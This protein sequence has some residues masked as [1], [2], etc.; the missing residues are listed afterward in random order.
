MK[1]LFARGSREGKGMIIPRDGRLVTL[2]T[3]RGR[4]RMQ[5]A[6]RH[7]E[8]ADCLQGGGEMGAL[9][10]S[11]DW[12]K[13]PLGPVSGW[14]RALRSMVGVLL[15][16]R[17]PMLLWWGPQFCQLYNDAYRPI[18]GDKHPRSMGQPASECWPEIW[19]IIG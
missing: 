1:I 19:H 5:E 14:S 10:R 6:W 13:T 18:P 12:S 9:M 11:I 7:E 17:F 2:P 15:R 16:N 3:P 8:S 4:D